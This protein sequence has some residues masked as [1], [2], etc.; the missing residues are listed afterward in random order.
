MLVLR[1][2]SPR[3]DC[4]PPLWSQTQSPYRSGEEDGQGQQ[5]NG[6]EEHKQVGAIGPQ[7]LPAGGHGVDPQGLL[8]PWHPGPTE[9]KERC[10]R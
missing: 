1:M 3:P 7:A 4:P 2:P 9:L 8:E 10:S 5:K 6:Q